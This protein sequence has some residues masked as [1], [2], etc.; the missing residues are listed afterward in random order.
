LEDPSCR[1]GLVRA[2]AADGN[3]V[4]S[5]ANLGIMWHDQGGDAASVR[6]RSLDRI[7]YV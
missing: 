4:T 3:A 6:H 7:S 2:N 5:F 1:I